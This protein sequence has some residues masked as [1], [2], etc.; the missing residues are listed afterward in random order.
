MDPNLIP[1]VDSAGLPGPAWLFHLLLVCTFFLHLLFMNL[2]LGGTLL[3]AIAHSLSGGRQD[4]PRG[5][6]ARRLV[7]MNGFGISLAITTGV[8]PLLFIQVLYHQYF[9]SATILMGGAWFG[10]VGLLVVGYY[11]AYLYKLR[12]APATGNGGGIWL[13]TTAL[14]FL[15]IA[16]IHVAV[17]LLHAQPGMWKSVADG[18]WNVLQD[19]TFA[20]RLLHFVLAGVGLSAL[21]AAWWAMRQAVRGVDPQLNASIATFAWKWALWST[22][23][24]VVDGVLFL[25]ILPRTVLIGVMQG[26]A[27]VHIPLTL[28]ILG[29]I[30]LLMMMAR[31]RNPVE[32]ASTVSGTLSAMLLVIAVM[33][34]TRHQIR[35]IYLQP[36]EHLQSFSIVPQ[37]FNFGLFAV[38]LLACLGTVAYMVRRV[39]NSPAQGADAA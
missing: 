18:G 12:G 2:A 6:L 17:H 36:T 3:A 24:L 23:A 26:G 38:V 25:M 13:W 7:T 29:A 16:A 19:P 5:A 31:V 39:L 34:V 35:L 33:S 28:G 32:S 21:V 37:W 9:Y 11:A 22:L 30:G 4:D 15:L 1:A 27:A 20:P 14:F 8:A 10:L